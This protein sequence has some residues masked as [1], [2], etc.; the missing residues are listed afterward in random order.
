[1]QNAKKLTALLLSLVLL[2]AL[3]ACG[4]GKTAETA[5][6]ESTAAP[7]E[8]TPSAAAE[9]SPA[10]EIGIAILFEADK[11][12][13]NNYSLLAV[14][15]DAPFAD[16]DGKLVEGVKINKIGAAALIDWVL[17][18]GSKLIADYG[19]MPPPPRLR[20]PQPPRK[21]KPFVCPPPLPSTTPVC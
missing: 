8:P 19:Q 6:S 5:S 3:A 10:A 21:Q 18:E 20:Y 13:Q 9:P 12:M 14:N 7:V 2:L 15:P 11:D 16:A 17:S 1:M 4:S